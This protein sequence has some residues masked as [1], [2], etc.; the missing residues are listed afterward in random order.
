M[1]QIQFTYPAQIALADAMDVTNGTLRAVTAAIGGEQSA[2]AA[3]FQ[4]DTGMSYQAWQAQW[5]TASEELNTAQKN[6]ADVYR[7][8]VLTMWG[9][10]Q[11][12]GGKWTG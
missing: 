12:E 1:S 4:G 2:L 8:S 5:N 10:D 3:G 9:R 6:M 11:G 7:Q